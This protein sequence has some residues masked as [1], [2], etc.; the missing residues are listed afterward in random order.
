MGPGEPVMLVATVTPGMTS[1]TVQFKD[2]GTNV[3]APQTAQFGLAVL[4]TEFPMGT[5]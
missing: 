4:V 2:G 1:G 5:P 3:G